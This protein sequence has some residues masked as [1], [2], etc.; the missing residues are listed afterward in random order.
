MIRNRTGPIVLKTIA[1]PLSFHVVDCEVYIDHL[2]LLDK[3]QVS[4]P[5]SSCGLPSVHPSLPFGLRDPRQ[6]NA[7]L[8]PAQLA[9]QIHKTFSPVSGPG[10]RRC[11]A[12]PGSAIPSAVALGQEG[13]TLFMGFPSRS[14]EG[15]PGLSSLYPHRWVYLMKE[16]KPPF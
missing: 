13:G 14:P 2:C 15:K 3:A 6:I 16:P 1:L 9:P 5:C 4:Q 10:T 7:A 11:T 8:V 12:D